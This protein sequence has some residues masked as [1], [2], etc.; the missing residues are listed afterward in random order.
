MNNSSLYSY[1]TYKHTTHGI[2]MITNWMTDF[3]E[4]KKYFDWKQIT[5]N[6]K[7]SNK[8]DQTYLRRSDQYYIKYTEY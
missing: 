7:C 4:Y 2:V 3:I 1:T 5:Y 8:H 6:F